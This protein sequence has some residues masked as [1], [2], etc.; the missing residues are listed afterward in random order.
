M[1][2]GRFQYYAV[3]R[4]RATRIFTSLPAVHTVLH[5]YG[6]SEY[7]GFNNLSDPVA[8]MNK[9]GTN[10]GIESNG[11][12][13]NMEADLAASFERL[14]V[15]RKGVRVDEGSNSSSNVSDVSNVIEVHPG[16]EWNEFVFVEDME[17]LLNRTCGKLDLPPPILLRRDDVTID[18]RRYASFSVVLRGEDGQG[19]NMFINGRLSMAT[20]AE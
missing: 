17:D 20:I 13:Q 9:G 1:E 8:Y 16:F 11:Y 3:R 14:H 18:G 2:E 19:V 5:R 15:A 6:V 10:E 12:T 7:K 4:G